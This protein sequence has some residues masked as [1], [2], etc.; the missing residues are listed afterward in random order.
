MIFGINNNFS[1]NFQNPNEVENIDILEDDEDDDLYFNKNVEVEEEIEEEVEQEQEQVNLTNISNNELIEEENKQKLDNSQNENDIE[2]FSN[3]VIEPFK[4]SEEEENKH[5][6]IFSKSI[7]LGLLFY[8]LTHPK[9]FNL[10][11][12]IT[13]KLDK[14][15]VHAIIFTFITYFINLVL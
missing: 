3:K 13:N 10:T 9:I 4:G 2:P 7:L 5:L 12:P 8:I 1:E 15:L 11:K 6:K 14:F